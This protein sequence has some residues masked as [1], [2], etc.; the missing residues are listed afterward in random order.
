M[1]HVRSQRNRN[2]IYTQTYNFVRNIDMHIAQLCAYYIVIPLCLEYTYVCNSLMYIFALV[3]A[4]L[5]LYTTQPQY[6]STPGVRVPTS[7]LARINLLLEKGR[8]AR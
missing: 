6:Y 2:N 4:F 8:V 5:S 1:P 7:L 3:Q